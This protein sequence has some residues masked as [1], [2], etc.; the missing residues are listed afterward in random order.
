[1][2][3]KNLDNNIML[4]HA[5]KLASFGLAV[6]PVEE[7]GKKPVF[8]SW[9]EHCTTDPEAVKTIWSRNPQYNIGIATGSK[10]GG[11]LVVD[12]DNHD[13]DGASSLN[14]WEQEHGALPETA[15]VITGSGGVHYYYRST[16]KIHGRT[17]VLPGVDI[18]AEGNLIVAPPSIHPNGNAYTWE[19]SAELG[20]VPIAEADD[21]VMLLVGREHE[22]KKADTYQLP[23][24]IRNGDRNNELFKFAS[25]MQAKNVPDFALIAAVEKANRERCE[26]P[27]DEDEL[28]KITGSVLKYEKGNSHLIMNGDKVRQCAENVFRVLESDNSL[29]NHIMY[30]DFS[31]CVEW[32][33]PLPWNDDPLS[34]E[35]TDRDDS[36]LRSYL[37]T[38]YGLTKDSAYIDGFNRTLNRH[39]Y[40]PVVGWFNALPE[41][42]GKPHIQNLLPHYV[43]AENTRYNYEALKLFMLG[44]I[45]RVF[46]PGCK[47][48]YVLVLVGEQG[49]GKSMFLQYLAVNDEWYDG[50]FSTID[51]DKAVEKLRGRWILEMAEL[52]AVKKQ[53]DVEAFKAFVT[54]QQDSYRVPYERRTI[55][56]KRMCVFAATTN[57]MQFMSDRTGNR[58]YLPIRVNVNS[59][60]RED[61]L[62]AD[63]EATHEEFRKAW[64]EAFHIY[65]TEHPDLVMPADLEADA[66]NEQAR[67]M[68]EDPWIGIIQEWLNN[69]DGRVCSKLLWD[70]ALGFDSIQG[71][72]ADW[73]HIS[74]IM[75][76]SIKGWHQL[77]KRV[78]CGKYGIQVCYE[79]DQDML[80]EVPPEKTVPF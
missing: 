52:L 34:G 57:D 58:R 30:N 7:R 48:D 40:N 75:A 23:D 35:W 14:E 4:E 67:Y 63:P 11:L 21:N 27:L 61:R 79:P 46:E 26:V 74:G 53:K 37:D 36:E 51:G 66:L 1:M 56:P 80:F 22:K 43:G 6:F 29:K 76:T 41:W 77:D 49:K 5:L 42:D 69:H 78:R 50:N 16:E 72:P 55:H 8:K 24:I 44:A 2:E 19:I 12:V 9:Q 71:K 20:D 33:G 59:V 17:N 15:T 73:K 45:S 70:E 62:N 65:K 68:E 64:A 54:V 32:F 31:R 18:R 39:H 38:Q 60:P 25:S 13:A 3:E 10:S 47:F 28:Q